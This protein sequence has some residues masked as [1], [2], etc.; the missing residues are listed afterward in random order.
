[1]SFFM[2]GSQK[3]HQH[4]QQRW[5]VW[6]YVPN[7]IGY[8]RVV[9]LFFVMYYALSSPLLAFLFY[10]I[11][12]VSDAL[13]GLAAKWLNQRS[14]LGGMLDFVT[15]RMALA[16]LTVILALLYHS[17]WGIFVIILMLDMASHYSHMFLAMHRGSET[18]KTV[19]IKPGSLL[20]KYY[21]NSK[22]AFMFY[23]CLA[24]DMFLGVCYLYYFYPSMITILMGVIFVPGFVLKTWI[25]ILQI[26]NAAVALEA[27]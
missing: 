24:H 6:L 26:M 19:G 21:D 11:S 25:H 27:E 18:H 7:L 12:G 5:P 17:L 4:Q 23:C 15:D 9:L 16:V 22:R 1:M 2:Q 10:F 14:K 3:Q 20:D 8:L 13:D